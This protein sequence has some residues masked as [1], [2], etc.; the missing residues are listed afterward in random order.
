MVND[1]GVSLL[2]SSWTSY[3]DFHREQFYYI[4]KEISVMWS[5][6]GPLNL[7]SA[8]GRMLRRRKGGC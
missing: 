5:P 4:E 1:K 6:L 7:R 3:G 2:P 8:G